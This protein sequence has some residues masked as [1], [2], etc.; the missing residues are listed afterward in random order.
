MMITYSKHISEVATVECEES[1]FTQDALAS[2][3]ETF[4]FVIS[5]E[6]DTKFALEK[7]K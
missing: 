6:A 1:F 7:C 4:V 5:Q 2:I 3:E